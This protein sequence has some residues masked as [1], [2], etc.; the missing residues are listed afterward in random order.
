MNSEVIKAM[1]KADRKP[2]AIMKNFKK[3]WKKNRYKVARVVFFPLWFVLW[4]SDKIENWE[5][6]KNKWDAGRAK[7]ILDYYIPR[8]CEYNKKDEAFYFFDN[9]YGWGYYFAK[10]HLK[11]KDRVFWKRN[12][13]CGGKMR[14]YLINEYELEGF[15]KEVVDTSDGRTEINFFLKKGA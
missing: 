4:L 2:F 13:S 6:S 5:Y 12:A 3:W 7:K 14:D 11:H 10:K 1:N 9:G 8:Y 15:I